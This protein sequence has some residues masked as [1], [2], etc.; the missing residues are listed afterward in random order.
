MFTIAHLNTRIVTIFAESANACFCHV[1][2]KCVNEPRLHPRPHAHEKYSGLIQDQLSA[3]VARKQLAG[4]K[5]TP[6]VLIISIMLSRFMR[7]GYREGPT[8]RE[9]HHPIFEK[10][11][12]YRSFSWSCSRHGA[13]TIR[14]IP[15]R[16]MGAVQVQIWRRERDGDAHS[17]LCKFQCTRT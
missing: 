11:S 14:C 12:I 5:D 1:C 7:I 13:D 15:E 16:A 6:P 3:L 2:C 10:L 8:G 17:G 9:N 4:S